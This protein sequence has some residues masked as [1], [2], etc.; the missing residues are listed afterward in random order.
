MEQQN[1]RTKCRT[2]TDLA[3]C[4]NSCHNCLT[5]YRKCLRGS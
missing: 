1:C 3:Q 4:L 2:A 5:D